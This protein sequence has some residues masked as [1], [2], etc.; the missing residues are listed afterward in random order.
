MDTRR[1]LLEQNARMMAIGEQSARSDTA[2]KRDDIELAAPGQDRRM[3][4]RSGGR[5]PPRHRKVG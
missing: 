4:R 1:Q 2:R 3:A 5:V